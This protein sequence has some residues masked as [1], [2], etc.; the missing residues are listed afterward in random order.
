MPSSL[1]VPRPSKT[2]ASKKGIPRTGRIAM[3]SRSSRILANTDVGMSDMRSS[4]M[5]CFRPLATSSASSSTPISVITPQM[6]ESQKVI[7]FSFLQVLVVR[8]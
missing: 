3:E 2:P 4:L 7:G 5:D 1:A 8:V 6:L